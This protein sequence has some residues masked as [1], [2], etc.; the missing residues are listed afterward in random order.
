MVR[1][2]VFAV[3]G[4]G[5]IANQPFYPCTIFWSAVVTQLTLVQHVNGTNVLDLIVLH[6]VFEYSCTM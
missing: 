4:L 6:R 1:F 5:F 3:L 2:G